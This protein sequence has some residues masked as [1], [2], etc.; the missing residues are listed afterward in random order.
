MV[1]IVPIPILIAAALSM[2]SLCASPALAATTAASTA[3]AHDGHKDFDFLFGTWRTHYEILRHPMSNSHNWYGCDGTSIV[4][5]FWGSSGNLEDGDLHCPKRTI[6]GLTLRMYNPATHEWTLW[7]GT[8][9]LGL[10]P[11]PQVGR[12]DAN[13]V[14]DFYSNDTASNLKLPAAYAGKAVIVRF[15]WTLRSGDHPHFEQ[16]FSADNGKTWE[17]NWTTVYTRVPPS[18]KGVWNAAQ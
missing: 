13:G 2:S 4:R 5:P 18:T 1:K 14:G 3:T 9:K 12:F 10:V 8:R 7:W 17:T 16:A 11:Q 6:G 15:R